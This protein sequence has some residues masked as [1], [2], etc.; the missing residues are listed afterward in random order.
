MKFADEIRDIALTTGADR[1]GIADLTSARAAIADQGGE[2]I[3]SFPRAVVAG[4]R[5][6]DAI[7]DRLPANRD[8]Q[9]ARSYWEAY[10]EI[11]Q[12]LDRIAGQITAKLREAGFAALPVP[13]SDVVDRERHYGIFSH[14]LAAHLAGLG[15]IGRSCLLIAPDAGPRIR[16]VTVLTDAPLVPSAG[17]LDPQC[18][19]CRACVEI[20]PA[21]AFSGRAFQSTE[22]RDLRFAAQ[23]CRDHVTAM[24]AELGCR[25]LCGLCVYV[26]PYGREGGGMNGPRHG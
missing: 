19:T 11:N 24:K 17:A 13:A 1:C 22:H 16:W 7:I 23:K 26:C 20:C 9:V 25:V 18:G 15:W 21:G 2:K 3:A 4:M 10:R 12:Y 8:A 5:L 14:K 6:P